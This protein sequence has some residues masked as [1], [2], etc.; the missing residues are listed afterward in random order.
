MSSSTASNIYLNVDPFLLREC[1]ELVHKNTLCH[2]SH[3]FVFAFEFKKSGSL[4][5]LSYTRKTLTSLN[6]LTY[7]H[8]DERR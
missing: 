5:V 8:S 4:K 7:I 6:P 3:D 1:L 2:I